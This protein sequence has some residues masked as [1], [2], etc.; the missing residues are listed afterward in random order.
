M[1]IFIRP[2]R[3]AS[4]SAREIAGR[5][6]A[7]LIRR[8]NSR[9]RYR[10]G[11]RII[12][13]GNPLPLAAPMTYVYNDPNAVGLAID[14]LSTWEILVENG[15]P[16]V[17]WTNDHAR[18]LEWM[19]ENDE[20]VLHRTQL[21][22]TQGRGIEVYS[23]DGS[24]YSAPMFEMFDTGGMYVKVFGRNPKHVTEFRVAVCGG[25]VIDFAQKKR[26]KDHEGRF[27]PY[28][29]SHGNGWVFCREAVECPASAHAAAEDAVSSLGLDFGAVDLGVS[30]DGSVCVYEINTA[31][32]IEGTSHD[33]WTDGLAKLLNG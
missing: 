22:G 18:A 29:R 17:Q 19:R 4:Q 21:R 20:R 27:N 33:R 6:G 24:E 31:P 7:R 28:V 15:V 1:R 2:P 10:P 12:N 23:R 5:L 8:T 9:Y 13:W 16:T 30:R 14:K 25:E 3:R 32:G 26:R 11:H